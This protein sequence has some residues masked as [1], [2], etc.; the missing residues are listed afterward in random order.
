MTHHWQVY[1]LINTL[2]ETRLLNGNKA[3][4]VK[5]EGLDVFYIKETETETHVTHLSTWLSWSLYEFKDSP[6]M[7]ITLGDRIDGLVTVADAKI[8][9][10]LTCIGRGIFETFDKRVFNLSQITQL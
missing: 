8:A 6:L 7:K 1:Q 2:T 4:F 5:L 10:K 9:T 3:V